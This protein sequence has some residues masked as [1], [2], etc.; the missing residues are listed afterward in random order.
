M[1]IAPFLISR[2]WI[3]YSFLKDCIIFVAE[4]SVCILFHQVNHP[5]FKNLHI[6]HLH[7]SR[8]LCCCFIVPLCMQQLMPQLSS[9]E[10]N[11]F[12]LLN[13]IISLDKFPRG[14]VDRPKNMSIFMD[15][16][17]CC[18]VVFAKKKKNGLTA[19]TEKQQRMDVVIFQCYVRRLKF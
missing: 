10:E 1:H 2:S 17:S 6:C 5:I 12:I 9:S 11:I 8:C 13:Q 18:N 15:F 7:D 16:S 19:Y 14:T 4:F 3:A